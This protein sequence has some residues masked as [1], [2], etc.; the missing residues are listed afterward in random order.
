MFSYT[1]LSFSMRYIQSNNGD[2]HLALLKYCFPFFLFFLGGRGYIK[3]VYNGLHFLGPFRSLGV[4]QRLTA[5]PKKMLI[6]MCIFLKVENTLLQ[7]SSVAVIQTFDT[8][9]SNKKSFKRE[10]GSCDGLLYPLS[11]GNMEEKCK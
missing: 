9:Y 6:G 10:L 4:F 5:R 1:E 7:L 2:N 8:C 11:D 3:Q